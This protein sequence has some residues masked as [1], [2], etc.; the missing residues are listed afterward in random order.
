M[1]NKVELYKTQYKDD[2]QR[3]FFKYN[4]QNTRDRCKDEILT[5]Q[6]YNEEIQWPDDQEHD[7]LLV[8]LHGSYACNLKCIYCEN[9][10]LRSEYVG[11]VISEDLVQQL[12]R[13]LGPRLREVTWHG[14][15]PLLLS[16]DLLLT[17]ENEKKK[18]GYDFRTSLQ[19]N[20][21]LL[22]KEKV[23]FLDDLGISFG[24]SFDG[25]DN[26]LSRGEASTN[27]ILRC[28]EEF[29]D[30]IGFIAVTH[31]GTINK[32]IDNY[33]YYKSIGANHVQ[34]AIVRENVIENDNPYMIDTELAVQKVIEYMDYWIHDT[35]HPLLD[36]YLTRFVQRALAA[37]HV[38]EDSYCLNGWI[39][40]DPLGNITLCGH[41]GLD[42][43]ICNLR[44]INNYYDLYYH[45]KYMEKLY[46]QKRLAKHCRE[47]FKWYHCCYAGCMGLHYEHNKNYAEVNPRNCEYDMLLMEAVYDLIKDIDVDDVANYNPFFLDTLRRNNY[48]SLTE[49]KRIESELSADA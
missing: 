33:E 20:S 19:T 27:S 49:I 16:E 1:L 44:D 9:Q 39:I 41:C 5:R 7:K 46:R 26:S 4:C 6:L 11:A 24:T 36:S 14:G 34:S 28:L 29:P 40:V 37:P 13:K 3:L 38:C 30:R 43:K 8:L 47:T 18:Y 21:L 17:L 22:S 2:D 31:C 15:E 48:Y 32:L 10:H 23:K 42:D 35:D 45:P 25:L 12:V